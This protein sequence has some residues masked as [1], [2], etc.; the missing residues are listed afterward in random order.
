MVFIMMLRAS[1]ERQKM[2]QAPRELITAMRIDRLEKSAYNPDVHRQNVQVSG[3]G[4]PQDRASDSAKT[5][6]HD[7]DGRGVFGGHTERSRVLMVDLVDVLIERTPVQGAVRPVMPCIL[8]N[9]KD[10]D[11]VSHCEERGERDASC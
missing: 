4:A 3:Y 1:P 5:E 2:M 7:F 11:L 8:E 10:G 9:K 6:D